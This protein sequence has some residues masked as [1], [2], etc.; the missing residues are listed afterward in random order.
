MMVLSGGEK[1]WH[2]LPFWH[3]ETYRKKDRQTDLS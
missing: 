3:N 1:V 2:L